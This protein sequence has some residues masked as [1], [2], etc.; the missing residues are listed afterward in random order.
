MSKKIVILSPHLDDAVFSCWYQII[1]QNT[2]VITIFAG[3]P[4]DKTPSSWDLSLGQTDAQK[5]VRLRR[6]ENTDALRATKTKILNLNNLDNSYRKSP[7]SIIEIADKIDSIIPRSATIIAPAGLSKYQRKGHEDHVLVRLVALELMN[8]GRQVKF[9]A[10]I[11]YMLPKYIL[12]NWPKRIFKKMIE[13]KLGMKVKIEPVELLHKQQLIKQSACEAYKTQFNYFPVFK[14][15][16]AYRWEV[17]IRP[18]KRPR[19][20]KSHKI[21]RKLRKIYIKKDILLKL[22]RITIGTFIAVSYALAIYSVI[23]TNMMPTKYLAFAVPVSF[24]IVVL[25][26]IANFKT[27]K[28]SHNKKIGIIIASVVMIAANIFVFSISSDTMS[29]LN[30]IQ[31]DGYTYA[32]YSIIAESDQHIKLTSSTQQHMGII[33]TDVNNDLVKNEVDKKTKV[34]YTDYNELTS[35]TAALNNKSVNM[36]VINNSYVQLLKENDGTFYRGIEVLSTFTIKVKNGVSIAKVDTTKPF[37]LYISGID[38]YGD[39]STVSRSDVNIMVVINPQ[40]H[41]LLL[42]NTPRDYYVQL[43]GTTGPKDKLTHSGIYGINMSVTTMQDLYNVPINYYLRINFSSLTKIVDTLGGVDVN[44]QYKF[45]A[46]GYSF[47]VGI[48]HLNGKQALAFSR[49]RHSFEGGDRTRGSNQGLVIEAIIAK[50]DDSQT[51]IN[52]QQI[53][54]SLNGVI[55]TN[56]SSSDMSKLIS[57]QLNDMSKWSVESI[58]VTGTDSNNYTYSMGNILLYVME[59]DV[60]SVSNAKKEIQQYQ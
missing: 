55:Q 7:P 52:Y 31:D 42:V 60:K 24:L 33:K 39:I 54:A 35:I 34:D 56:M 51:I 12:P 36:A 14:Q 25:L 28:L 11:P 15:P 57:A 38:T 23:N 1:K 4:K 43:H 44:S 27:K 26:V 48:N 47:N 22:A 8:R 32:Q 9:Y 50:M 41:K 18:N 58:S 6:K 20:N 21:M 5:G 10:D 19:I 46:D 29:F 37:I 17:I 2:Q 3:I 49:E 13:Y 59:P 16:G 30:N 45:T 40:T 53:L